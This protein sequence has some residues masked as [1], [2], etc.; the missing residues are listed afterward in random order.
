LL[1][2][3]FRLLRPPF[4]I[5]VHKKIYDIVRPRAMVVEITIDAL[6]LW[7]IVIVHIILGIVLLDIIDIDIYIDW[8]PARRIFLAYFLGQ[9]HCHREIFGVTVVHR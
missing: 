7:P 9:V 5:L 8:T 2:D 3:K 6:T 1:I 4:G